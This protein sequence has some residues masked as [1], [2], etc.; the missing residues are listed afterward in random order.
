MEFPIENQEALDAVIKDRLARERKKVEEQYSDYDALKAENQK[1][2]EATGSQKTDLEK[3]LE[4]IDA[5]KE[6]D[7][8]REAKQALQ[9]LKEKISKDTG[10]PA[11]L[12]TGDDE[13]SMRSFADSVAA[14]A[15]P[16]SAPKVPKSG[17][18]S[19]D[20]DLLSDKQKL[21]K[22]MFGATS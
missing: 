21:A 1:L 20:A 19:N 6:K 17:S 3:A 12:I 18:F 22:E 9:A 7:A 8:Q 5:L 14:F 16:K 4:Q 11:E 10:I 15:K 2:K 13:E